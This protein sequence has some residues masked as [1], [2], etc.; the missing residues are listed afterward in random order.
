MPSQI[1]KGRLFSTVVYHEMRRTLEEEPPG[2]RHTV[3][4]IPVDDPAERSRL[5]QLFLDTSATRGNPVARVR[6]LYSNVYVLIG[7]F[8]ERR[9][10][11][12]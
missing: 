10:P 7:D 4:I 2:C 12:G 8:D 11:R 6:E 3:A 1:Q 9:R 5:M